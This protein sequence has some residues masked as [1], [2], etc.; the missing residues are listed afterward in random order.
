MSL[1]AG[2]GETKTERGKGRAKRFFGEG[3]ERE[4]GAFKIAGLAAV[5][6]S[7][8]CAITSATALP[9]VFLCSH[10]TE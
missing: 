3:V 4:S 5:A 1:N 8:I 9:T 7:I 10:G 6:T 2:F